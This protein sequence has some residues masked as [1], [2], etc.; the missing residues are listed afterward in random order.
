[1]AIKGIK[2]IKDEINKLSKY[3]KEHAD[4]FGEVFTDFYLV[5]EHVSNI[6]PELFK[7]PTSTFLDPCAGFGQYPIILIEKLMDG[8]KEW[9]PNPEKRYKHIV[10][11]QIFMIE[12]QKESCDIIERLFNPKGKYKLNLYNMSFFDFNVNDIN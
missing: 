3:R 9:E 6:D 10:E 5:D 7:D 2:K 1:M 11:N 12:L 8:L 4:T